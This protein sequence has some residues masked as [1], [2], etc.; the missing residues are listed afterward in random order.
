MFKFQY[1]DQ[2]GFFIFIYVISGYCWT[3]FLYEQ[4]S[5]INLI[6]ECMTFAPATIAPMI[7]TNIKHNPNP[8]PNPNPNNPYSTPNQK[9]NH[10]PHS[11]SLLLEIS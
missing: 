10:N 4:I 5:K 9:P 8:N 2:L 6:A 3:N 1:S 7:N 11:N